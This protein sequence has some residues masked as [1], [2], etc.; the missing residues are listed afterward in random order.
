MRLDYTLGLNSVTILGNRAWTPARIFSGLVGG[1]YF[2]AER[3]LFQD[4]A[5]TVPVTLPGQSVALMQDQSGQANH[6]VQT[7]ATSR[8]TFGRHPARGGVNRWNGSAAPTDTIFWPTP[9][10]QNG[11]TSTVVGS[12]AEGG[13]PYIDVRWQGVFTGSGFHNTIYSAGAARIPTAPAAQWTNSMIARVIAGA[14][15]ASGGLRVGVIE[16]T[17]PTTFVGAVESA[18]VDT[19]SDT[20]RAQ[21]RVVAS[22]N[23]VRPSISLTGS[24]GASVDVT[25]RIKG[26]QFE[27]GPARTAYQFNYSQFDI[28]E[29]GERDLFYIAPDGVDDFMTLVTP[30]APAGAH[31]I[32]VGVGGVLDPVFG[33]IASGDTNAMRH[34]TLSTSGGRLS[35]N[36]AGGRLLQADS[37]QF[38][39]RHIHAIRVNSATSGEVFLNGA[40]VASTRTGDLTPVTTNALFRF[41]ANYGLGRFYSGAMIPVSITDAQRDLLERVLAHAAG[42]TL[43]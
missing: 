11:L 5:G 29:T 15:P 24:V 43:P 12:G 23:Q 38:F 32:A 14:A 35:Y 41:G 28:T 30:F 20:E 37:A 25:Y 19:G 36:I 16:E 3:G 34:R 10:E 33:N 4:V 6:A 27:Q 8:P 2:S 17:A 22:G 26:V 9:R 7:L 13:L 39:Q 18:A 40:S 1:A 31:T 42:V 21:S